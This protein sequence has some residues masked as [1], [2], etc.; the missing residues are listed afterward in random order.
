MYLL[1]IIRFHR[2]NLVMKHQTD[3]A[4][5]ALANE[6]ISLRPH[7]PRI[8]GRSMSFQVVHGKS[9]ALSNPPHTIFFHMVQIH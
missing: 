5:N 2:P 1:W 9:L 7:P 4:S 8:L 3:L 6:G